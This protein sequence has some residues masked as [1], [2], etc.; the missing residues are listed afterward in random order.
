MLVAGSAGRRIMA[1]SLERAMPS[2]IRHL[3]A[4]SLGRHAL[5][6]DAATRTQMSKRIADACARHRLQC[7]VWCV[8]DRCLHVVLRGRAGASTLAS[9]ELAGSRLRFGHCLSTVVNADI[10]LLEVARHA[11]LAPVRGRFVRRAIDWPHSSAREACGLNVAPP[12][13]DATPLHDL[14]GPRDGRGAERF[15]RYLDDC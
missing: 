13:L 8:T 2:E 12:W 10:Y 14:L 15:R 4:R 5:F 3:V 7:L 11:L 6:P 1:L 9:E